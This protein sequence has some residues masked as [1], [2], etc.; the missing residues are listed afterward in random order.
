MLR[1]ATVLGMV[2][3]LLVTRRLLG[4]VLRRWLLLRLS[5]VF[6]YGWRPG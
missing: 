6:F 3:L 5:L 1:V 4:M 2:L